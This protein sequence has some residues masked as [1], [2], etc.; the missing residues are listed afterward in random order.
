MTESGGTSGASAG[1]VGAAAGRVAVGHPID[2]A[3]GEFFATEIDHELSG[4]VPVSLGRTYN[5][6]F[7]RP[8]TLASIGGS[9]AKWEPFGPGWR[10][11]WLSEL[12]ETMEGFVYTNADGTEFSIVDPVGEQSLAKT[13]RIFSPTDGLELR[14]LEGGRV[15]IVGYGRDRNEF[16]LVFEKSTGLSYR[17]AAIERTREARLEIGYDVEGRPSHLVQRRER[18]SYQLVHEGPRV[19]RVMV[20]LPDGSVRVAAEYGY[21]ARGRLVSVHDARGLAARYAHDDEGRIVHDEKRGGSVYTVRYGQSGRCEY[22]AGSDAYQERALRYDTQAKKT[23]VTDSHGGV[24][25]YEWNDRGQVVKTQTPCGVVTRAEFDDRGRPLRQTLENGELREQVYDDRGRVVLERQSGSPDTALHYDDEHRLVAYE[26]VLEGEVLSRGRLEYD[27]DHNVTS[28]QVDEQPAWRYAWSAFGE[29]VSTTAPSGATAHRQYDELGGL[30]R[31]TNWDGHTWEWTHDGLGR[32][33]TETDPLGHTWHVTYLDED[34]KSLRL[35][36]PDGRVYER[37]VSQDERTIQQLL[38]GGRTRITELSFCGQPITVQDEEGAVTRLS[39]GTEPSELSA[40][41]NANGAHYT[42]RYDADLR[43]VERKTFDGRVLRTGWEGARVAATFDGLGRKTSYAYD[44]RGLV[45]SQ[46][47]DDGETKLG[48]DKRGLLAAVTTPSSVLRLHRDALGRVVAE[49]QDGVRIDRTLDVM[50][51]P[52]GHKTPFGAEAAFA[53][54]AGGALTSLRYGATEVGFE[55]DAVGRE[56]RRTLGDAGVFE[57]AYD[58]VGRLVSQAFR[59]RVGGRGAKGDAAGGGAA[60]GVTRQFGFDE[61]GFLSSIADSLRGATRLMHN[62]RGDLTGVVRERGASDFYAY[63]PCQNRVYHAATEHGAAL[64]SALDKSSRERATMGEVPVDL[65]AARFP[66]HESS[67]GYAAGDRVVVVSRA[68]SRTELTYDANGQVTS[69][70][71][72]RGPERTTW[73]YAWNARGE[74]VTVTTPNGKVWTYRYDGAG[75]RIEKKSPTGDTWRYVWMGAV[76]LHTLKNDALA[77][78]YVHEPGGTC[79]VLRATADGEVRFI[80]P[81]RNDAP[82]EEVSASGELAWMARKGTWGEGFSA[83]GASGG[84]PA[85]GQ[86]YDAESGLH[87][88]FFRYYDPDVGRFLSP[89]PIDL[90]GGMNAYLAVSDPYGQYD[91]FGLACET[92][93][94]VPPAQPEMTRVRHY[95]NRKGSK[96]IEADG[97]IKARDNNRVYVELASKKPLGQVEAGAKYQLG[98]GRGRDYVEFDVPT[99]KLEIVPNPRYGTPELTIK[100]DVAT[101]NPTFVRRK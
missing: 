50:G 35:V 17:L 23:W 7:L 83:V 87:Y 11:T 94:P 6:K 21:D 19:V 88:N 41:I 101:A 65:V 52:V 33:L 5:T 90:L 14:R 1:S 62:A 51:R 60:G 95:T 22:A 92:E 31:A 55:R 47:S 56:T 89:D 46:E 96:G 74:L 64:A 98:K 30:R 84:E 34:G 9:T 12:R 13:G 75:R 44:M 77:E 36:E 10:P 43:L 82:S 8:A 53:W 63:D 66:H 49:E 81:D 3:S 67:F 25:V 38:P 28:V 72:I 59:A 29:P 76:L 69:K 4:V 20:R 16:S 40:I 91:Q 39:W 42:F 37:Q 45:T 86:W 68:D 79:P 2:V 70:S 93:T 57:Q 73:G 32:V 18:R 48:Y 61:C 100:G 27:E 97:T 78:T 71:I 26:E 58:A 80:L 54:S 99:S 24:T 85:L 15:R